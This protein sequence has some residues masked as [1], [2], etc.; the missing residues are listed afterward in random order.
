MIGSLSGWQ[1]PERENYRRSELG[2]ESA[3][4]PKQNSEMRAPPA[5][6]AQT[7]LTLETTVARMSQAAIQNRTHVRPYTVT[8]E[9]EL[10]GEKRDNAKSRVIA[11]VTFLPP[12]LRNYHIQRTEGSIIGEKIVRHMLEGEA[13][14]VKDGHSKDICQDN[15]SFRFLGEKVASG[16]RC[17]VLQLLPRRKDKS[18]LYGIIW[19]DA[20]TYLIRRVEGEPAKSPSWWV[21]DVNC[22]WVYADVGGIWQPTSAEFTATVRLLGPWMMRVRD[23]GYSYSQFAGAGNGAGEDAL[24]SRRSRRVKEG[25]D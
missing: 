3:K 14:V 23:L 20:D 19:V 8:R 24:V 18:L 9:Y 5:N 17:Y 21:R 2:F 16:R 25:G 22:V 11:D 15:Y 6:A 1:K 13:A 12:R 4:E 7:A 10:F